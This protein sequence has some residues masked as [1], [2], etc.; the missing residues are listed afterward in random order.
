MVAV[1]FTVGCNMNELREIPAIRNAFH[2]SFIKL[3]PVNK[4]VVKCDRTRNRSV[5]KE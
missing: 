2:K 4:Q 5:I 1:A 3:I